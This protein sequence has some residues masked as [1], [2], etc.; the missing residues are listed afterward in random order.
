MPKHSYVLFLKVLF[1]LLIGSCSSYSYMYVGKARNAD[2]TSI[3]PPWNA[4]SM[5]TD[6]F[7]CLE[8]VDLGRNRFGDHEQHGW[9]P[10]ER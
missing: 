2:P 8:C 5:L 4:L 10:M 7:E 3:Y 9:T 6:M 1:G